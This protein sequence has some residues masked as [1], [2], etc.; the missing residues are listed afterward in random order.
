MSNPLQGAARALR[1]PS[2]SESRELRVWTL[3][4]LLADPALT[5]PPVAII[6]SLAYEGRVTLLSGREKSGKSTLVGQ[7]VAALS[8]GTVFLDVPLTKRRT[9]WFALDEQKGDLVR[10]ARDYEADPGQFLIADQ[11]PE[12]AARF[13]E[14]IRLH[15]ADLVVVDTLSDLWA[16]FVRDE[17]D[18]TQVGPFVRQYAQAVRDTGAGLILLHH[19]PKAPGASYRGS[20]ALGSVVDILATLTPF[21]APGSDEHDD[22]TSQ[23]DGRRVLFVRGRNIPTMTTRL[24]FDGE[25]YSRG[26]APLPLKR[27]ILSLLSDAPMSANDVRE[28]LS[29][30]K[31][32]V[33]AQLREL[34]GDGLVEQESTRAPYVITSTG[35]RYLAGTDVGTDSMKTS[36]GVVSSGT[37]LELSGNQSGTYALGG[38]GESVPAGD[39]LSLSREPMGVWAVISKRNNRQVDTVA[40]ATERD[41]RAAAER[42]G[43]AYTTHTVTRTGHTANP[44]A[45]TTEAP[46]AS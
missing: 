13:A 21:R 30:R 45:H 38:Q 32:E 12:S 28:A 19:L 26:D 4:E 37:L 29:K 46:H 16:G 9:L 25:R 18:A 17:K 3:G 24:S 2:D 8:A 41:A 43:H 23:D 14:V 40:A 35:M 22:E 36:T 10:R 44:Q 42:R 34:R 6:P 33:L 1:S 15:G 20:T 39:S 31:E 5:A 7:A 27:R 11:R